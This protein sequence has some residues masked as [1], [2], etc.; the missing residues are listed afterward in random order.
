M[1]AERV[2]VIDDKDIFPKCLRSVS[3]KRARTDTPI[4]RSDTNARAPMHRSGRLHVYLL[5][6]YRRNGVSAYRRNGVSA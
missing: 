4:H 1:C 3:P 6:A 5:A 2:T